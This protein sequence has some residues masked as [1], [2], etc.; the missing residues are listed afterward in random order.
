[1]IAQFH[2]I[3]LSHYIFIPCD[4]SSPMYQISWNILSDH[5]IS[6]LS[7]I[8]FAFIISTCSCFISLYY[9]YYW[10]FIEQLSYVWISWWWILILFLMIIIFKEFIPRDCL[11]NSITFLLHYL[12]T[13]L[14]FAKCL[15]H[16]S[17][18]FQDKHSFQCFFTSWRSWNYFFTMLFWTKWLEVK[19]VKANGIR[20]F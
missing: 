1:L 6:Y 5:S 17:K 18:P 19:I 7:L 2:H 13:L 11:F 10:L 9:Y 3:I 15:Q 16:P 8:T 14:D 12:E 4:G 20:V